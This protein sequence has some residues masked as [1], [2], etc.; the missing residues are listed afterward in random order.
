MNKLSKRDLNIQ[1]AIKKKKKERMILMC[2]TIFVVCE[3]I[4]GLYIIK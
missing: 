3:I 4:V 2:M 1:K